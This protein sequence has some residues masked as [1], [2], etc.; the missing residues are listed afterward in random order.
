MANSNRKSH[1]KK[2]TSKSHFFSTNGVENFVFAYTNQLILYTQAFNFLKEKKN[3][4]NLPFGYIYGKG[5][6]VYMRP[7]NF[8]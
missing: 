5:S 1:L 3:S 2:D 8:T 6:Q 7:L 4:K